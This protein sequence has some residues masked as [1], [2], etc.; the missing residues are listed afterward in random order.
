M[1]RLDQVDKLYKEMLERSCSP[2]NFTLG[3]LVKRYGRDNQLDKAFDLVDTL[4][5]KYGFKP[6]T[7]E[8]TCLIS[9]CLMNRQLPRAVKV[10]ERMKAYGPIP[11]GVTYERLI[12]GLLRAGE[13][14]RAHEGVR[15]DPGWCDV[16]AVDHGAVARGEG[17]AGLRDPPRCLRLDEHERAQQPAA[18]RHRDARRPARGALDSKVIESIMDALRAEH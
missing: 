12:A 18:Q 1:G 15:P 2:T 5:P 13:G 4:P 10:Y 3:V 11:D 17:A 16:R 9:A 14:L 8:M 6:N 7:Q